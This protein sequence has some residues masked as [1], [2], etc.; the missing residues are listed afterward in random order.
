MIANY[1][2]PRLTFSTDVVAREVR[3]F[4]AARA[5]LIGARADAAPNAAGPLDLEM[6]YPSLF[7]VERA[8]AIPVRA[9]RSL[10]VRLG[11]F[12]GA[13]AALTALHR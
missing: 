3:S 11:I 8:P 10:A 1:R 13:L 6:L 9:A 4:V 12:A 5:A 7:A 2:A